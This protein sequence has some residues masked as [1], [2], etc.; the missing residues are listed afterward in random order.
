MCCTGAIDGAGRAAPLMGGA[1]VGNIAYCPRGWFRCAA[2]YASA[3]AAAWSIASASAG[4]I[5]LLPCG[6]TWIISSNLFL[7]S[8]ATCSVNLEYLRE[9]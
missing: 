5:V 9:M 1:A 8:S 2:V 6:P 4:V 3:D 7:F